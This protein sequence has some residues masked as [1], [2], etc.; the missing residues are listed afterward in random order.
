MFVTRPVDYFSVVGNGSYTIT[1]RPGTQIST[2][3]RWQHRIYWWQVPVSPQGV[4]RNTLYESHSRTAL[5]TSKIKWIALICTQTT[6][7]SLLSLFWKNRAGLWD[8][9]AVRVCISVSPLI[10]FWTPEAIF[11]KLGT[12]IISLCLCMCIPLSLLGNGSVK[13]PL[14]LLGKGSVETLPR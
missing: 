12:Y 1:E 5:G 4:C 14:S 2:Y 9:V 3:R 11:M 8:H 13:I 10:N 7:V 6:L